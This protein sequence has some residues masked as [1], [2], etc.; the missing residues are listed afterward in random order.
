MKFKKMVEA[1]VWEVPGI[2]DNQEQALGSFLRGW[3]EAMRVAD[4]R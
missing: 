4:Q 1:G 2:V 3:E